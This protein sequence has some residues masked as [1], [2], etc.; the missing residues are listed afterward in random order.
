MDKHQA[1][2]G[3]ASPPDDIV[4]NP[5]MDA[6][7]LQQQ[8]QLNAGFARRSLSVALVASTL[9]LLQLPVTGFL[10][11]QVAHPPVKYFATHN[12]SILK[13]VPT[14]EPAYRDDEIV[15]FGDRLIRDAFQLDFRNYRTQISGLQQKFS[16]AGF[17]SYYSALTSSNLFTAVKDQKMLMSANVTRKGVIQKRGRLGEGPYMWEIQYPVTLSLDGQTRSLPAQNFIFTVRI[18][19]ADVSQKPEGIEM[20]SIVTRDAR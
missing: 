11:W 7:K 5:F 4:T 9:C 18:Q 2:S 19:R 6:L 14:S 1:S 17:A 8:N 13:Q 16:E 3:E 12:G 20:A 10:A 15:A